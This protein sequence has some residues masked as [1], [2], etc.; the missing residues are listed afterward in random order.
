MTEKC[1]PESSFH[2]KVPVVRHLI[3]VGSYLHQ[4]V[5]LYFKLELATGT[6]IG[7][8]SPHSFNSF[9][10]QWYDLLFLVECPG[11]AVI[12]A[13]AAGNT[14]IVE[15]QGNALGPAFLIKA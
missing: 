15:Q 10:D 2:T 1:V 7:A 12:N 13:L 14:I 9:I 3:R 5:A 4:S 8:G 6:T 11:G